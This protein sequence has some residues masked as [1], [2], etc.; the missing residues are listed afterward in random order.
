M[1]FVQL[2]V[3]ESW[4]LL[5][6]GACAGDVLDWLRTFAPSRA[7]SHR[8]TAVQFYRVL[9]ECGAVGVF[10]SEGV[11]RA[12]GVRRGARCAGGASGY[13]AENAGAGGRDYGTKED[14]GRRAEDSESG[15]RIAEMKDNGT[16]KRRNGETP[17]CEMLEASL[18]QGGEGEEHD[19]IHRPVSAIQLYNNDRS[20][21]VSPPRVTNL[22]DLT[23]SAR[24]P[25]QV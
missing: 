24:R 21:R 16:L 11:V 15:K 23:A 8:S 12:N 19:P 20:A 7:R 18:V 10:P 3:I 9:A 17:T 4:F 2:R 5:I 22:K 6:L 1:E 25:S 13:R 14:R